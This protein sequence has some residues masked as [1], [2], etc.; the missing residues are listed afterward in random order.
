VGERVRDQIQIRYVTPW[1]VNDSVVPGYFC[2]YKREGFLELPLLF[3]AEARLLLFLMLQLILLKQTTALCCYGFMSETYFF[4]LLSLART[5][6]SE[7][8]PDDHSKTI[9]CALYN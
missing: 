1:V 3:S 4:L 6:L 9:H 7:S 5:E 8:T 2:S